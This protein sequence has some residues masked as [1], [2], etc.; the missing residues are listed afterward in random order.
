[1][2]DESEQKS[3]SGLFGFSDG[4]HGSVEIFSSLSNWSVGL[5]GDKYTSTS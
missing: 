5:A 3:D 4:Y 1:M 2:T